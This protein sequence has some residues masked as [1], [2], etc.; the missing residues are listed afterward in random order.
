MLTE[1]WSCRPMQSCHL[2]IVYVKGQVWVFLQ[3]SESVLVAWF[4]QCKKLVTVV[5][6]MRLLRQTFVSYDLL[7][8][9]V[10]LSHCLCQLFYHI[11]KPNSQVRRLVFLN[12]LLFHKLF[13]FLRIWLNKVALLKYPVSRFPFFLL[14]HSE[15]HLRDAFICVGNLFKLGWLAGWPWKVYF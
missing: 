3:Q 2:E 6:I 14:G 13:W 11:P 1:P 8:T 10:L 12:P 5:V 9:Q 4:Y 7:Q 15:W